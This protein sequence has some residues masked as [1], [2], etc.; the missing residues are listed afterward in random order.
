M[1]QAKRRYQQ[2]SFEERVR[3]DTL[4]RRGV[5]LRSIARE[6]R[7][8]PNTISRELRVKRVAG[9]YSPQKAQRKTYHKRHLAKRSCL[10][11]ATDQELTQLVLEKL[12]LKWSP[13]RIAGYA[14]LHGK[15]VSKKA[16][17]RFVKTRWMERDLLFRG[18]RP[19]RRAQWLR[20]KAFKDRLKRAVSER[21]EAEG[22]GHWEVDFIV[23]WASSASLLV[24][25]DRFS[26]FVVVEQLS[27]R[28]QEA[29]LRALRGVKD[30]YG[31]RSI[32]VD[33]DLAFKRW[34][35]M[36]Q[37][38]KTRFFFTSP[39]RSYEKGL[40]ENTNRWIRRFVPKRTELGG[41]AADT[42]AVVDRYLN[43][44]PRQVLGF[45]T[46]RE[47]Q[48]AALAGRVS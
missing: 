35:T 45:K 31:M 2:L 26:R 12:P 27:S 37:Q 3:I 32:T 19:R 10:K 30:R 14:R 23:S 47:I 9:A 5:S 22:T 7:R 4:K 39:Y 1:H 34:R 36:E 17:Y 25:V 38:L 11:V 33:N 42:L 48:F 20:T 28:R 24:C 13:E 41:V 40:V 29:V 6:L 8:S 18:K 21:P 16:I 43:D 15:Q 46:A 44:T